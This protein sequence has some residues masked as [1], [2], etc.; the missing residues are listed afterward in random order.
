[1]SGTT[2]GRAKQ[3]RRVKPKCLLCTRVFDDDYHRYHSE[4]R[5]QNKIVRYEELGAPKNPFEA[6]KRKQRLQETE[7]S[8]EE[9]TETNIYVCIMEEL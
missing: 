9:Q 7:E 5:K 6:A 2:T 8:C 3:R 4:Y 1:M